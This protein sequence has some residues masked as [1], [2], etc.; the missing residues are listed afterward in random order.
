MDFDFDSNLYE[1]APPAVVL[2]PETPESLP[3]TKDAVKAPT[4]ETAVQETYP[5]EQ[6]KL[7]VGA[8]NHSQT[9]SCII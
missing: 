4:T 7:F 9:T 6:C 3:E 2:K 5:P 1:F 8:L